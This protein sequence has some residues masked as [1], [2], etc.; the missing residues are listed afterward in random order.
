MIA[1]HIYEDA[2]PESITSSVAYREDKTQAGNYCFLLASDV[3]GEGLEGHQVSAITEV[4]LRINDV[5]RAVDLIHLNSCVSLG[6]CF[7]ETPRNLS[8]NHY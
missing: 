3:T 7:K 2:S 1:I 4:K 8:E 6:A 5:D